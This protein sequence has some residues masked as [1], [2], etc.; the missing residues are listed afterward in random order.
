M[1]KLSIARVYLYP[2]ISRTWADLRVRLEL[3][4]HHSSVV[5]TTPTTLVRALLTCLASRCN[6]MKLR[7]SH[8]NVAGLLGSQVCPTDL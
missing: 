4:L 1:R 8:R 7:Y 3:S 5:T 2:A 6:G